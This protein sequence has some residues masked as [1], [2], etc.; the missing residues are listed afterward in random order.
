M[1]NL[2]NKMREETTSGDI[3]YTRGEVR[4]SVTPEEKDFLKDKSGR[5]NKET[6]RGQMARLRKRRQEVKEDIDNKIPELKAQIIKDIQDAV[7]RS[8]I[9]V[10]Y[11][12]SVFRGGRARDLTPGSVAVKFYKQSDSLSELEAKL[13]D[14][15][16]ELELLSNAVK[17]QRPLA[18]Y[19][20]FDEYYHLFGATIA[21]VIVGAAVIYEG[22]K[23]LN[24]TESEKLTINDPAKADLISKSISSA[25]VSGKTIYPLG[26]V[27]TVE[28]YKELR[29]ILLSDNK[30]S[31][32]EEI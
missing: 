3:A 12:V 15:I 22:Y 32:E 1:D 6:L 31:K 9:S 17:E 25:K 2:Y 23:D 26:G 7:K 5:R 8:R 21:A 30:P 13:P 28:F 11:F 20:P 29:D 24:F 10:N 14:D 27:F 19:A 4:T 18:G 16:G